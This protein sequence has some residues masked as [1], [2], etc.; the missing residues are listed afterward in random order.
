VSFVL[1]WC[2]EGEAVRSVMA[3]VAPFVSFSELLVELDR[4]PRHVS[5]RD[6]DA[7]SWCQRGERPVAQNQIT[8]R[9]PGW[10]LTG[11]AEMTPFET[12][13]TLF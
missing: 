6:L 11:L 9:M 1:T 12:Q 2:E 5:F 8:F 7:A 4:L 13:E 3:N 10:C